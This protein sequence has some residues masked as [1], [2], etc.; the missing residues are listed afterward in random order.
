MELRIWKA[1][2]PRKKTEKEVASVKKLRDMG[3]IERKNAQNVSTVEEL[4]LSQENR[5]N[6]HRSVRE[7]S[8]E[9]GALFEHML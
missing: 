6:T 1:S 7:I 3:T 5:P 4:A 9:T 8:R 2:F